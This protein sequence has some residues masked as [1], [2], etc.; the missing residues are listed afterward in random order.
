[1]LIGEQNLGEKNV[2][3]PPILAH[4]ASIISERALAD[5]WEQ[6]RF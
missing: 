2:E 5:F 1:M 6:R 3:L 4:R